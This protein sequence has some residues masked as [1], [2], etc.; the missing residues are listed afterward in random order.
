MSVCLSVCPSQAGIL[1][2]WLKLFV[3]F[4]CQNP[5]AFFHINTIVVFQYRTVLENSN[6]DPDGSVEFRGMKNRD[7]R[8]TSRSILQDRAI[9]IMECE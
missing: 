8:P 2:K 9:V 1:S 6:G 7:F 4:L 3:T 5:E